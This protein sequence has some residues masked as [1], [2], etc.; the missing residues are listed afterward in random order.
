MSGSSE[1]SQPSSRVVYCEDALVW[2]ERADI[3]TGSSLVASLPDISEFP[4]HSLSQWKEWFVS[5]AKLLLSKTPNDGVAVFYQ[6]D[7]K[8]DGTWIDKGF[9]CQSAAASLGFDTLWHKI[10]CRVPPGNSSFGRC[11]Y[12]HI[13]CFSRGVRAAV[14]KSSADVLPSI[15]EKTW[16]RGMGLDA[17][18]LVAR[19]IAEETSCRTLVHPF[20]GEGGMLAVANAMGLNA[21]GIERSPKRAEAARRMGVDLDRGVWID[22]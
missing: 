20:C 2:L 18:R 22:R 13:L 21:I 6:S 1:K 4:Q 19:F 10:G 8:S 7:I 3:L 11:G 5:A 16:E 14:N 12:S 15:G 9:L 17:C